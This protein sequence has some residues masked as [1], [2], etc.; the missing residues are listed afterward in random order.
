MTDPLHIVAAGGLFYARDGRVLLVETPRRGW[1]CPGGQ[2][3]CG[4]EVDE[5]VVREVWEETGCRVEIERLVGIYTNPVPPTKVIFMFVGRHVDG[6]PKRG[7]ELD[8]GWFTV[9]EALHMVTFG[10]EH[11]RLRDAL[12]CGDRPVYRVYR[13]R[14]YELLKESEW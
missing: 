5:A 7:D 13:A 1:E 6:E 4:E 10:P 2:V 14:P 12:E 9:E 3:E 8:P 11:L